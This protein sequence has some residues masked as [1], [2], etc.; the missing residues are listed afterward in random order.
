[1]NSKGKGGLKTLRYY[2]NSY[3]YKISGLFSVKFPMLSMYGAA[4]FVGTQSTQASQG[5]GLDAKLD[6]AS[7]FL[8]GSSVCCQL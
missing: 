7:K 6:T 8:P 1:M 3:K 5:E 2:L 4:T